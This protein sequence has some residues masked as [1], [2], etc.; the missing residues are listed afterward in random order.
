MSC[1]DLQLTDVMYFDLHI[2][3]FR[4]LGVSQRLYILWFCT[5]LPYLSRKERICVGGCRMGDSDSCE[6][7]SISSA[8]SDDDV[9]WLLVVP[10][11]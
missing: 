2:K 8:G 9:L 1:M 7:D 3:A 6:T 4:W 5:Y 11:A 10:R